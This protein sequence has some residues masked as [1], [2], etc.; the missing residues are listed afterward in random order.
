LIAL[1]TS[2]Y[3]VEYLDVISFDFLVLSHKSGAIFGPLLGT[4]I[5]SLS[6]TLAATIAFLIS[7]YAARDKVGAQRIC[8]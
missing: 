7:R 1:C 5:V 8:Y 2:N 3:L 4:V 6:G